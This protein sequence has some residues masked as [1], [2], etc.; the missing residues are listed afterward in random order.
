MALDLALG[1][2]NEPFLRQAAEPHEDT[3][4]SCAS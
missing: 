1:N 4:R 3:A 2:Y